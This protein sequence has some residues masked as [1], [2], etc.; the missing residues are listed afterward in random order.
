MNPNQGAEQYHAQQYAYAQQ[1]AQYY[2]QHPPGYGPI[3]SVATH[4]SYPYVSPHEQGPPPPPPPTGHYQPPSVGFRPPPQPPHH[5]VDQYSR[6]Q[7]QPPSSSGKH[8][9]LHH[10]STPGEVTAPWRA[11]LVLHVSSLKWM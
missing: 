3:R 11:I 2:G 9:V 1:Y 6:A 10:A 4:E 5:H 7:G 8:P